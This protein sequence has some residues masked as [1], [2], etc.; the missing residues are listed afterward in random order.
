MHYTE[1]VLH[2]QEHTAVETAPVWGL[3]VE[4]DRFAELLQQRLSPAVCASA[5]S[6]VQNVIMAAL[7]A[8]GIQLSRPEVIVEAAVNDPEIS[9][10]ILEIA[11]QTMLHNLQ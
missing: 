10:E 1:L 11:D 4:T 6:T 9:A 5:K 3:P 2:P 7:E 8:G